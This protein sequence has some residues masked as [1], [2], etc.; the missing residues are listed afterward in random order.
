MQHTSMGVIWWCAGLVGLWLSGRRNGRPKRNIFP[1]MVIF[2]T[3]YA[4]S[5]HPQHLPV[6]AM[7]HSVF[8]YTLMAAGAVR[9]VEI[10]FVLKDSS[11]LTYDG[12]EANSFQYL[13]PF[14]SAS[15]K[16]CSRI[17]NL[18]LLLAIVRRGVS[19]HGRDRRADATFVRFGDRPRHLYPRDLQ[20]CMSYVFV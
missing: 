20:R 18:T 4:M 11:A 15:R 10:C 3:G 19:F 5:A 2:M 7:V 1:A 8:G 6:S 9:V 13:T 16:F 12:T 14:V 17:E